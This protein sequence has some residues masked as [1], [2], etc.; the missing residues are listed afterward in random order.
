MRTATSRP[1]RI[2]LAAL[3]ATTSLALSACGSGDDAEDEPSTEATAEAGPPA[4]GDFLSDYTACLEAEG[5]ELGEDWNAGLGDGFGGGRGFDPEDAPSEM[6][7][8]MEFPTD[9]EMPTDL[10]SGG[11]GELEAP[12]GVSEEDWQAA[13]DACAA[14]LP[15]GPGA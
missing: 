14:E 9:M 10:P 4:T 6:P 12:E 15:T 2:A 11:F 8:D 5:I 1:R 7:T 3:L 13:Q